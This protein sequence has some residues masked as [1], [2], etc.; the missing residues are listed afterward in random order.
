MRKKLLSLF[1]LASLVFNGFMLGGNTVSADTSNVCNDC[2]QKNLGKDF[3]GVVKDLE[4]DGTKVNLNVT[5]ETKK[6]LLSIVKNKDT[7][8]FFNQLEEI[9]NLGFKNEEKANSFVTFS[10]LKDTNFT[11]KNVGI[12]TQFYLK[13][14]KEI[15]EKQVWVDLE[16]KEVI[17]YDLIKI[18]VNSSGKTNLEAI[19]NYDIKTIDVKTDN[20]VNKDNYQGA[21]KF[22][23]GG[24]SF[25]CSVSGMIACAAA[26]GGLAVVI[27]WVGIPA[28]VACEL[29]FAA[30]CSIS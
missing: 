16:K 15:V 18:T 13:N 5:A 23:F 21:K 27:P 4:R 11:Y 30:G 7:S 8:Q 19:A 9:K 3:D 17:R 22:N 2:I 28:G 24:L 12:V 1:M 6:E 26:F 14:N 25:A 29:A 10:D 20:V